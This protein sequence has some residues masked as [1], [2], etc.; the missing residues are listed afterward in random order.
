MSQIPKGEINK[1]LTGIQE[2]DRAFGQGITVGSTNSISGDPGAGKTTLLSAVAGLMSKKMPTLY[3]TAEE[4]VRQFRDRAIERLKIQYDDE[5]FFLQTDPDVDVIISTMIDKGI[6]FAIIDSINSCYSNDFT[7]SPGSVSQIKGCAQKLNIVAKTHNITLIMI[8][9]VNKDNQMAGPKIFGHIVDGVFHIET[10][11]QQLRILRSSK[12]RFGSTDV[13]GI[14]LMQE[15]GMTS[16]DNPSRL[17]LSSSLLKPAAGTAITCIREGNRNILLEIQS[18]VAESEGEH[19]QKVALGLQLNRLKMITAVLKKHMKIKLNHDIYLSLIGGLKLA[20]DDT[21][22]DLAIA[23]SLLSSL[24]D[25]PIS[26]KSCAIG[27]ISLSGEIRPIL[28]GVQRIKE[29]QKIGFKQFIVP[30]A[31]YHKDMES[32][33]CQVIAIRH[34]SELKTHLN[35]IYA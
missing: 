27:E 29:A 35:D 25:K 7:G 30:Y 10:N 13:I 2:F 21:S 22:A 3:A 34:I 33:E 15:S 5:N 31:N 16:V 1:I 18:L 17:F 9:H 19:G 26:R 14:F 6:K 12:N 8:A 4:S 20:E 23:I 32:E 11:E 24:N 28:G